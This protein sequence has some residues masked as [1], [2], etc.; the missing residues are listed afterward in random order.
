MANAT[1]KTTIY[2]PVDLRSGF[3]RAAET[4]EET[5]SDA[6]RSVMQLYIDIDP[7]LLKRAAALASVWKVSQG[8]VITRALKTSLDQAEAAMRR[9]AAGK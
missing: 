9:S 3:K 4:N 2:L 7:D 1:V 8:E 5:M 6:L